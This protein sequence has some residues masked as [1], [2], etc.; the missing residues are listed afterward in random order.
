MVARA[1]SGAIDHDWVNR[2]ACKGLDP[3]IFYPSTDEEADEAKAVCSECPVQEACLERTIGNR[4]H[5]GVWG[6][7][8]EREHQRIIR[9]HQRLRAMG[10]SAKRASASRC[11]AQLAERHQDG[12][13]RGKHVGALRGDRGMAGVVA[14]S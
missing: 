5:N 3:T 11:S 4:E 12:A 8:T 7:A 1:E 2:S 13:G 6:G 10:G 14:A 9:R